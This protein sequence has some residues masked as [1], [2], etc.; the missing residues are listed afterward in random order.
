[1]RYIRNVWYDDHWDIWKDS[2]RLGKTF[3]M[4]SESENTL[5][6]RSYSF[7]GYA[8]WEKFDKV[9]E[10]MGQ[11]AGSGEKDIVS[12]EVVSCAVYTSFAFG[13]SS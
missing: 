7:V 12:Q 9:L 10:L 1:M 3:C 5:L 2:I 11:W 13:T 8:L 4:L 6:S